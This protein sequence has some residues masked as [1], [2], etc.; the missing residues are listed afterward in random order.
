MAPKTILHRVR[1]IA[2]SVP[3]LPVIALAVRNYILHQSA[4]QAGSMAFSSVLAMF[5]LLILLSATAAY[6]GEPGM[7]RRW[8]SA[9]WN[10]RRRWCAMRCS[11]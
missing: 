1:Q 8:P 10:T 7:R 3:G 9:C 2:W 6:V 5:P 11:R 4:N